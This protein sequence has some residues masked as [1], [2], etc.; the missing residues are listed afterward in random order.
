MMLYQGRARYPVREIIVHCSAT[1]PEWFAE[2]GI[3]AKVTEIRT[4]HQARGWKREGYHWFVDRD[5]AVASGRPETMIGAHVQGRN[6][7][8]IGICLIG[9]HGS[10]ADDR[11]EDHFT[12]AQDAALRRLI[13]GVEG[14]TGIEC[15][16]GHNE[17]AAK[18]CPGFRVAEWL[19]ADPAPAFVP[20]PSPYPLW[21][22]FTGWLVGRQ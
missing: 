10:S 2:F 12:V 9:G 8:T 14:R 4:W 17:Y 11:F 20:T 6:T 15:V 13:A 18:A 21:D 7:G 19:A 3:D 16:S 5:G 1:R 22:R